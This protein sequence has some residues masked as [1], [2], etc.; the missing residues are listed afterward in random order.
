MG[1]PRNEPGKEGKKGETGRERRGK[2][3]I[4]LV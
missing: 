4:A 1:S 3:N 2:G